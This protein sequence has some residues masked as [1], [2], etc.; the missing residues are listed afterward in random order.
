MFFIYEVKIIEHYIFLY[1]LPRP[2]QNQRIS[3][4]L[5][6]LEFCFQNI[7]VRKF[8]NSIRIFHTVNDQLVLRNML[9]INTHY[10]TQSRNAHVCPRNSYAPPPVDSFIGHDVIDCEKCWIR[11][12]LI[13][14]LMSPSPTIQPAQECIWRR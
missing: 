5:P 6:S 2:L 14:Y 7:S 3:Y 9:K 12:F 8:K 13:R 10:L 1:H 11:I 4:E